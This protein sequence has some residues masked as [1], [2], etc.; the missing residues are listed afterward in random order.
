M[1]RQIH[2]LEQGSDDWLQ[3]RMDHYGASEA[4]A[5][6][7]ISP[8]I[9]RTELLTIKKTG[10]AKEFSDFVQSRILDK[11][12]EVEAKARVILEEILEDELYPAT[13]SFGKLSASCDG[14]D[15]T[16]T[17]TF[18]H[19]QFNQA[20]FESVQNKI[21]PDEHQP[22]CQ[23]ILHVT[24]ANR[25]YFVC[26]DGT[27]ENFAMMEVMP[28]PTWIKRIIKGWDQFEKDLEAFVPIEHATK[29]KA[30]PVKALPA[31]SIQIKGEVSLSNLPRFKEAADSFVAQIKTDLETDQ[32]FADAEANVKFLD[33]AEKSLEQAK[34][35]ALAQTADIDELMR[36]IDQIKESMKAKRLAL[37][38]LVK[39]KKEQIKTKIVSD[40]NNALADHLS[41]IN[42]EISPVVLTMRGNFAE[43]IKNK[44][45]L[46][47]LHDAVDTELARCKIEAD[48]KAADIRKN[49]TY[50]NE[51]AEHKALF[52]DLATLGHQQTDAFAAIVQNRIA[53]YLKAEQAKA[54]AAKAAQAAIAQ[55]AQPVA[56]PPVE[57]PIVMNNK[58]VEVPIANPKFSEKPTPSLSELA[59]KIAFEYAVDVRTATAWIVSAVNTAFSTSK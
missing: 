44:R 23:Q 49:L 17:F 7:G 46:A 28:D 1:E 55:A 14:I 59:S 9:T 48:S 24:G 36:T 2:N 31:L 4:A 27:R 45:T 29:P 54:E 37:D 50:L 40:G 11:G 3:F 26:S 5:M 22:Q 18:E 53:E 57:A 35:A 15:I 34:K 51:Y 47:S 38:K 52:A 10:I 58:T 16:D 56:Q 33:E 8:Y 43:A 6:L 42:A 41:R 32:D 30:E 21:L 20:L 13:Y 39:S 25:I 19:K 12:H